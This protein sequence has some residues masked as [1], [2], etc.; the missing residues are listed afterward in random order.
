MLLGTQ[1]PVLSQGAKDKAVLNELIILRNTRLMTPKVIVIYKRIPYIEKVGNVRVTLDL[2]ISSSNKFANFFDESIQKR[3][4]LEERMH[5]L[6]IK[7]DEFLPNYIKENLE[8]GNLTQTTFS[9]Y[10][11]CRR[12]HL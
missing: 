7:F 3:P 4:V 5:L 1:I 12:Y 11:Y 10:Y 8:F 6:E 9:K 2:N